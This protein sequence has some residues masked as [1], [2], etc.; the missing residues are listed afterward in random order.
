MKRHFHP[1][2]LAIAIALICVQAASAQEN[3]RG[4]RFS[5]APN[6]WKT[7]QAIIPKGAG[8]DVPVNVRSGAVPS[9]NMLGLDP[10][11][12]T[13]PMPAPVYQQQQVSARPMAN[14]V[15]PRMVPKVAFNPAFGNPNRLAPLAQQAA[16]P[17]TG[18]PLPMSAPAASAPRH[19][20]SA[21]PRRH[22]G[23]GH[24]RARLAGRL[25]PPAKVAPAQATPQVASYGNNFG[26]VPGNALPS[27]S[28]AGLGAN[29]NVH[30]R[31][32]RKH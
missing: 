32:I 9:G 30:G 27:S 14:R 3:R 13:K 18:N 28:S 19:I 25:L 4:A 7:E 6:V 17:T 22:Y 1:I 5:Y 8:A 11:V 31:I 15:T 20:A 2:T 16:M 29:A 12:L 23:G 26:Y 10:N 24:A 21:P